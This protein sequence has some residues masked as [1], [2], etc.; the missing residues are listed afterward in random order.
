MACNLP[1]QP[2]EAPRFDLDESQLQPQGEDILNRVASCLTTG[3]LAGKKVCI[4]G[5][6][7]PRGSEEHNY[8]LGLARGYAAMHHLEE[9][10]VRSEQ[11]MV[12]SKGKTQATGK[13][14]AGWAKDR[15]V[16]V[17]LAMTGASSCEGTSK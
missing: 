8:K 10:G 17:D 9:Q 4:T 16:E 11:T 12:V 6:T 15:R 2:E 14:E 13:D 7:D 3:P 5:F 1:D